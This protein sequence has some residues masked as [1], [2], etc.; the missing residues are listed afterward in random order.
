MP[1][2]SSGFLLQSSTGNFE[3]V[4]PTA[5]GGLVHVSRDHSA[6]GF[7]W[8]PPE[9]FGSGFLEAGSLIQAYDGPDAAGE[10]EVVVRAGDRLAHY[11][12]GKGKWLEPVY[13]GSGASGRPVMIQSNFGTRGNYELVVPAGDGLAHWYRDNDDP[14]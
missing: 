12:R 11:Q 8:T 6:E 13:F 4:I 7:P 5:L 9:F 10:L 14:A 3:A 1:T 2:R